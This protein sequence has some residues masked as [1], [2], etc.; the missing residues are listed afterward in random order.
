MLPCSLSIGSSGKQCSLRP[1]EA[2]PLSGPQPPAYEMME[3]DERET[4]RPSCLMLLVNTLGVHTKA[5]TYGCHIVPTLVYAL[6]QGGKERPVNIPD[7]PQ[8]YTPIAIYIMGT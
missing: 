2:I 6:G 4:L 7:H 1:W 3:L 8:H 5:S